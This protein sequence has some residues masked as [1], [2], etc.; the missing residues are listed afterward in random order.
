MVKIEKLQ[1]L[2][3]ECKKMN[4]D[5]TSDILEKARFEEE[6]RFFA[7]VSDLILQQKQEEVISAKRF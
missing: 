6:T 7:L 2:Y 3:D 1:E 4:F 5:E